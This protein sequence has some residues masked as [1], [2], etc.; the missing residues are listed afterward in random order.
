MYK[1]IVV[2][3]GTKVLSKDDGTIDADVMG[4]LAEQIATLK[5][6]SEVILVTSGAVGY[7][8]SLLTLDK[9]T[10]SVVEKQVFA[11]VGQVKLMSMYAELFAKHGFVCAQVLATKE[12]FRDEEHYQN[13]QNCF[14][15]L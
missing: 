12:D 4:H 3:V 9:N 8:R 13:M 1:R 6:N 5:K 2:K 7:G 11:A 14:E 15:G 10:D